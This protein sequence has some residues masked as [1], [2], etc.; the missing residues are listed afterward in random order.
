MT[1]EL[2]W[3]ITQECKTEKRRLIGPEN[4]KNS[5]LTQ[6]TINAKFMKKENTKK[7]T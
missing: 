4:V 6:L 3:W 2:S 5:Y 7:Y 1:E